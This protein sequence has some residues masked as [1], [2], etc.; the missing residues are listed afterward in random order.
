MWG[1][2]ATAATQ[3]SFPTDSRLF[4]IFLRQRQP[5]EIRE[6]RSLQPPYI[7]SDISTLD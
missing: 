6:T 2:R 4:P 7:L 5:F 3:T 1:A